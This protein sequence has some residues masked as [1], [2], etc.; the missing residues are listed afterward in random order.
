MAIKRDPS[1]VY[2]LSDPA[3][4]RMG[5]TTKLGNHNRGVRDVLKC[6]YHDCNYRVVNPASMLQCDS[7]LLTSEM[8]MSL[9]IHLVNNHF[10]TMQG[11]I[12]SKCFCGFPFNSVWE[13]PVWENRA[14]LYQEILTH[15]KRHGW[16]EHY[17]EH[18][19]TTTLK[20]M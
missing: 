16:E 10:E 1:K 7:D 15:L 2:S 18:V 9:I 11:Q 20:N 5:R 4:I 8:E 17:K 3:R 6:W 13:E 12:K 19:V 14:V